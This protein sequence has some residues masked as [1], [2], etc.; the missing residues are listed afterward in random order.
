MNWEAYALRYAAHEDRVARENFTRPIDLHDAPMPM[1]YFFWVL[2]RGGQVIV[3]DT[4]FSP[5]VAEA[6][7]RPLTRTVAEALTQLDIAPASVADVIVTHLHHDH[8]GNLD[9]FPRARFHL[10]EAEMSFATG[11][12]MTAAC[13]RYPFDLE[14]VLRMVR[15]VYAERVVFHDGDGEVA[16][17]VSLHKVGGHTGGMQMVSVQTERGRVV[18][19]SDACHYYANMQEQNPFVIVF[20]LGQMIDGWRLAR[21][22]ATSEDHIIPGHDPQVR[23]RYPALAG[24]GGET[25]C[26]H[27]PT[28]PVRDD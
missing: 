28:R 12:F 10:Q 25:V 21:R 2:R 26:L 27:L 3:V 17:G 9:L 8:A 20:D 23:R 16:P 11:R 22:I 24:S 13:V 6:R 1:D 18:L 19:A 7:K 15:A 14:D 4:G 5:A